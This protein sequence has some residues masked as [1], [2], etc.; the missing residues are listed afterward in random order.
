MFKK[1]HTTC[2]RNTTVL[3]VGV[4]IMEI[5]QEKLSNTAIWQT[6]MFCLL[7]HTETVTVTVVLYL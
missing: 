5:L 2:L 1:N 6:P 4:K 7:R 3:Q